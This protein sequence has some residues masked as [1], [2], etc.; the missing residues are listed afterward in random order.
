MPTRRR[1]RRASLARWARAPERLRSKTKRAPSA[2]VLSWADPASGAA[3][4]QQAVVAGVVQRLGTALH[5]EAAEQAPQVHLHRVLAD[6]ELRG[7]LAVAHALV[8]HGDQLRLALGQ[9]AAAGRRGLLA[10]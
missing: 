8:E 1:H 7:D 4:Q 5:A 6:L 9:L 3:A 2:R 10:F